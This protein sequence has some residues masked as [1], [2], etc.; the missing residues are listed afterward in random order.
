MVLALSVMHLRR[1]KTTT[2]AF[3]AVSR[4]PQ[5]I[6]YQRNRIVCF[7]SSPVQITQIDK[8]QMEEILE[9][10]SNSGRE[11][12]GYVVIDVRNSDEIAFTG[13]LS[14]NVQNVPLPFIMQVK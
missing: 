7:S 4:F 10:L 6:K 1:L 12:T 2:L 8:E 9:D 14:P 3:S 11:E 5:P 13:Q